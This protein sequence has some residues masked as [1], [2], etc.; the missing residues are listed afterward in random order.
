[1][2]SCQNKLIMAPSNSN[3]GIPTLGPGRA[4]VL[5]LA[6][7]RRKCCRTS[8]YLSALWSAADLL[9]FLLEGYNATYKNTL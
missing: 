3:S 9:N 4:P 8:F 6:A 1:M 2:D 7:V 5:E